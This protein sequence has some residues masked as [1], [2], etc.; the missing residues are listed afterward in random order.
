MSRKPK[1][2]KLDFSTARLPLVCVSIF[3]VL[4][5][6]PGPSRSQT[7]AVVVAA[8]IRSQGYACDDPVTGRRNLRLSGPDSAVWLLS[9]RNATYRVRLDPNMAAHVIRLKRH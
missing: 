1:L 6:M 5:G 8:Q 3:V 4:I 9:C 7:P 2:G